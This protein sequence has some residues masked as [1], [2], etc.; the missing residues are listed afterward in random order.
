ME[1]SLYKTGMCT[2][3]TGLNTNT[4]SRLHYRLF[5]WGNF[6]SFFSQ[7]LWFSGCIL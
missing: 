7:I 1:N 2:N 6:K 5:C 4:V 3:E